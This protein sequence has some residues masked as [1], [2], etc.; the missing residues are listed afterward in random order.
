MPKVVK[1]ANAVKKKKKISKVHK[2]LGLSSGPMGHTLS[3]FGAK[4]HFGKKKK[5]K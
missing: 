1:M 4:I 3:L 2:T 5:K